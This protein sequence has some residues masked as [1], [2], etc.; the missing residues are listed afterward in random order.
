MASLRLRGAALYSIASA[1]VAEVKL[2]PGFLM[3]VMEQSCGALPVRLLDIET[4]ALLK[5]VQHPLVRGKQ[6]ETV[7]QFREKLVVKQAAD[8]RARRGRPRRDETASARAIPR[9][10]RVSVATA[11][12]A[13]H[14][15]PAPRTGT[16]RRA[17]AD[18]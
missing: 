8:A 2:S 17:S 4:G 9:V 10:Q 11:G 13:S 7:E 1:G 3:V 12:A 15:L 18:P 16:G 14:R 5:T 6:L